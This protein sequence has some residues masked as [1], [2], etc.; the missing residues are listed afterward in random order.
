MCSVASLVGFDTRS[1]S[2]YVVL[3]GLERCLPS[4]DT[5]PILSFKMKCFKKTEMV[6]TLMINIQYAPPKLMIKSTRQKI[7]EK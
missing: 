1:R 3:A 7:I 6:I 5:A 2:H 4:A